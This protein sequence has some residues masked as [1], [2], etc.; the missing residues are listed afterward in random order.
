MVVSSVAAVV[1]A[2]NRE[3]VSS[4]V[5]GAGLASSFE[6][7]TPMIKRGCTDSSVLGTWSILFSGRGFSNVLLVR[8]PLLLFV[9]V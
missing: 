7:E 8:R 5:D 3:V 4:T 6:L 9:V 2:A 1:V